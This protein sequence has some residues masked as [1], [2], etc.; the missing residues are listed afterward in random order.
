MGQMKELALSVSDIH[1]AIESGII[2]NTFLPETV[3]VLVEVN[4]NASSEKVLGI[5]AHKDLALYDAWVCE[6][7]PDKLEVEFIVRDMEFFR[8]TYAQATG[9]YPM[10]DGWDS[11][12]MP[13]IGEP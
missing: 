8:E 9:D 7:D 3:H 4:H 12:M 2:P 10:P 5:Y 1:H 13:T 6:Q 11:D